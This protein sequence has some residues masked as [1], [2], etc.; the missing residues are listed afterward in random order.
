MREYLIEFIIKSLIVIISITVMTSAL[1][2]VRDEIIH[3]LLMDNKHGPGSS[4]LRGL[5]MKGLGSLALVYLLHF[6]IKN[7]LATWIAMAMFIKLVLF[8]AIIW[9]S[10]K[11]EYDIDILSFSDD[12]FLNYGVIV[13]SYFY[14]FIFTIV[15]VTV[16][17][18]ILHAKLRRPLFGIFGPKE[19]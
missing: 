2:V 18:A 9:L 11:N 7:S 4:F 3:L 1:L 15:N 13:F 5:L 17:Y 16:S 12:S 14:D 10:I 19:I 8:P 6:T